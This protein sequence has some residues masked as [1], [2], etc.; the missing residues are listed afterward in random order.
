MLAIAGDLYRVAGVMTILAAIFL[1][2]L[3][4]AVTRWM[5]AHTFLLFGH[6]V[7]SRNNA[8]IPM[9]EQLSEN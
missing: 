1:A 6:A 5:R 3:Y 8:A 9:P 2:F 7:T 4:E